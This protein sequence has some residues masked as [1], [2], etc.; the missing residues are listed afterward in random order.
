MCVNGQCGI[1][2]CNPGR[3]DLDG[4]PGNGC[5]STQCQ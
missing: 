5:E 2:T 3:C 4:L 1:A